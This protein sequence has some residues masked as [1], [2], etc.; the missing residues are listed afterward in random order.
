MKGMLSS[1]RVL[2]LTRFIAGPLCGQILA[3]MGATVYKVERPGSG[4]D[5]RHI[6]PF[7]K[8]AQGKETGIAAA[9]TFCNRGKQ[10]VTI[11]LGHPD[12]AQLVRDLARQCDVVIENYK[13]GGLR[14]YGLDYA[15]LKTVKPDIVYC[16]IT[17]FGQDGPYAER[18]AFDALIQAMSGLMSVCGQPDG[19]PGAG[20]LRTPVYIADTTTG[21]YAAIGV[22]GAL[23][24]RNA[25]GEGQYIDLAL[26]D[27][28][29]ALTGHLGVGYLMNGVAARRNGNSNTTTA[30]SD[31]FRAK[32]GDMLIVCGNDTQ[33]AALSKVL[34]H[35]EWA[36]DARFST[37]AARLVNRTELN[38]VIEQALAAKTT[39]EWTALLAAANV[40]G[41]P[42]NSLSNAFADPQVRHRELRVDVP[43][44][45]TG[46][47]PVLR[48]PLRFSEQPVEH[49]AIP[50]LGQ[51]TDSV[52][53]EVLGRDQDEIHRLR[54]AGVI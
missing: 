54:A 10:S 13:A 8:D 7:Q 44:G 28:S 50:A 37:N 43:F 38:A 23:W 33:F 22:L 48:N 32:D 30:P 15:S 16:S 35:A 24:H 52:L 53:R 49:R 29:I 4:D 34:G 19:A 6:G 17:G 11:D 18:P 9:F 40:P 39:A 25:T 36:N 5:N 20:P 51:H 12:G 14:K 31:V 27:T 46:T 26:L 21:L 45:E 42:I 2:D 47:T 3:D 41:G 1:I